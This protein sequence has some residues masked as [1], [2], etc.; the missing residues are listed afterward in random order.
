ME[1]GIVFVCLLI[2]HTD[3]E[4][5]MR[6]RGGGEGEEDEGV[7]C[8]GGCEGGEKE[9]QERISRGGGGGECVCVYDVM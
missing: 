9:G 1:D 3:K 4:D 5:A 8:G 2:S 6:R 7:R